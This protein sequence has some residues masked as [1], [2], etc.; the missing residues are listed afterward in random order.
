LQIFDKVR[1]ESGI[2]D[3]S[4]EEAEEKRQGNEKFIWNK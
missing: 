2:I 1:P 4:E 3:L